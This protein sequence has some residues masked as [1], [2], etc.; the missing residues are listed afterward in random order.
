MSFTLKCFTRF[1]VD[2][3]VALK[4]CGHNLHLAL[5]VPSVFS[6]NINW[7]QTGD[8]FFLSIF[9]VSALKCVDDILNGVLFFAFIEN[10]RGW[11]EPSTKNLRYTSQQSMYSLPKN[12]SLSNI[13]YFKM[14]TLRV[15]TYNKHKREF[16]PLRAHLLTWGGYSLL[17]K[18]RNCRQEVIITLNEQSKL[19]TYGCEVVSYL[20]I[21]RQLILIIHTVF[22]I[23]FLFL[24]L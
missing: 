1:V 16:P 6:G 8:R 12:R 21:T 15:F 23:N 20:R 22:K 19:S 7:S 3:R 2:D 13:C 24:I 17:H 11:S 18:Q 14:P 5:N 10:Y 9:V 4:S